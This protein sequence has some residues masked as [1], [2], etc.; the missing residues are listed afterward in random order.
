[1]TKEKQKPIV[2]LSGDHPFD[3]AVNVNWHV[4]GSEIKFNATVQV[5]SWVALSAD[6][7]EA[8]QAQREGCAM[9]AAMTAELQEAVN[10]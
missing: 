6:F 1:M 9:M 8:E 2:S 7:D 10:A 3:W 5:S 4:S